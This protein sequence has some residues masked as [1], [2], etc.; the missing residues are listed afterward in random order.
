LSLCDLGVSGF[1]GEN[2]SKGALALFL[3]AVETGKVPADR[4]SW[5]N[6]LIA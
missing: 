2:R 1:T 5:S 3:K 6:P 4:S